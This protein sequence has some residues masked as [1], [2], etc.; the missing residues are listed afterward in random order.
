MQRK[1]E[2][3]EEKFYNQI[4]KVINSNPAFIEGENEDNAAKGLRIS[5]PETYNCR[6]II[7]I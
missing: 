5:P 2:K 3:L 6:K 4:G 7:Q 1:T